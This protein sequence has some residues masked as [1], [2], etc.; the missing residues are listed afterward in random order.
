M[1]EKQRHQLILDILDE[2]EFA[3][4]RH[5]TEELNSSEATIRR[6][7]LK[8]SEQQQIEK[9]RGGARSLHTKGSIHRPHISGDAFLVSKEKQSDAKRLIAKRAVEHCEDGESI[10]INGGS[11]TFMMGEF[12]AQRE[13]SIL[14]NSFVLAQELIENSSNQVTLPGGE[15]YRRQGIILSA[16]EQDAIQ[17]YS[18]SKMFMSTSGIV[19][20]GVTESDPLLITAEQKLLR[21][22]EQL[23]ILADSSKLDKRSKFILCPL[24]QVD[25][26]ITD[27][28]ADP[29]IIKKLE[30]RGV[31]VEVVELP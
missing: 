23:I 27:S 2:R 14:T 5:L 4:V 17:H 30:K 13:L 1:L 8:M 11:S 26:L 24:D 19:E 12:L 6:D 21:Q 10:I 29:A 9:I 31:N 25:L 15:V 22:A 18:A 3:S 7:L 16:Y 28:K 20:M